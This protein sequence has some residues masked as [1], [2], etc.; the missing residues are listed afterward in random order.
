MLFLCCF[1]TCAGSTGG[2]IKMVRALILGK[3]ALREF[4]RIVHPR[5]VVPVTLGGSA[6]DA[7]VLQSV[8]AFM[9]IYGAVL[10]G[11]T[12]LLLFTGLDVVS[13]FTAVVASINNTG[14]GLGQVGPAANYQGLTD[15][16]TWVCTVTMLLGRLELFSILVLFTSSF[17]RK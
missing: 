12:M 10:I 11:A 13:A 1:A 6:V 17:W 14:P 5:A 2:G 7:N 9:L 4:K 15:L 3:G 8:L 16:Q